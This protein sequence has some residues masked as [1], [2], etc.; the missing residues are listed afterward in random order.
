M[1]K[2]RHLDVPIQWTETFTKYPHGLT[3]FEALVD[4]TSQVDKMVDNINDWNDY[5]DGFVDNFE[6][7]LQEEVKTTI[8]KWQDEG[9]LDDIISSAL[10]TDLA[11]VESELSGRID[12]V[13]NSTLP[14]VEHERTLKLRKKPIKGRIEIPS[15]GFSF[16]VGLYRTAKGIEHDYKID[17]W[18]TGSRT[19]VYVSDSGSNID[20]DGSKEEPFRTVSKA[21]DYVVGS[22]GRQFVVNVDCKDI[23][24]NEFSGEERVYLTG[25]TVAIVNTRN[26]ITPVIMGDVSSRVGYDVA[27]NQSTPISWSLYQ[28]SCYHVELSNVKYI[29]DYSNK[30]YLNTIK[31]LKE[32]TSTNECV[33]QSN[34]YYIS[35]NDV[36]VNVGRQPDENVYCIRTWRNR[37]GLEDDGRLLLSGFYFISSNELHILSDNTNTRLDLNNVKIGLTTG[38]NHGL[39]IDGVRRTISIDCVI[40]DVGRDCYNYHYYNRVNKRE[41]GVIEINNVG[42][43][44]GIGREPQNNNVTSMHEGMVIL[45]AGCVGFNSQG[46]VCADVGG[47]YSVLI[48]CD[49]GGSVATNTGN[50]NGY[51]F[52]T[53]SAPAGLDASVYMDNCNGDGRDSVIDIKDN[54]T[55]LT[56]KSYFNNLN[57][58]KVD[59]NNL[60]IL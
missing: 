42:F 29:I 45:R 54:R 27:G 13:E 38:D 37:F 52:S 2:F 51:Y 49:M 6:F 43:N 19:H 1:G 47:C 18:L 36:Y 21:L 28:G 14:V 10:T 57:T 60:T 46:T 30:G 32:V 33:A 35:G 50:N 34:S 17:S 56:L 39:A 24:R 11:R 40:H 15:T 5:L 26:D 58:I 20:G 12:S 3:I 4:W 9:L 41:C 22:S 25:K 23:I 16:G 55:S 59:P 31:K 44:A 8:E 48:D 7:E 53:D